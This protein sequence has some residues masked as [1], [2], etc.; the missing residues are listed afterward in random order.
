MHSEL[1]KRP[2]S[3]SSTTENF[4]ILVGIIITIA[5]AITADRNG[6]PQKW[7][8]AI[9][10]TT[11]PF[12]VALVSYRARWTRWSF[13]SAL[14]ICLVV[15]SLIIWVVF[16]YVLANVYHF[17]WALWFPIAFV[18][19]FVLLVAVQKVEEILTGRHERA[20]LP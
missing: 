13:W 4:A 12:G 2:R 20:K 16:Q 17:G 14:A 15:H 3:R 5:L 8:A 7:H 18:E 10:G 6:M 11:V 1:T 9:F 19:A